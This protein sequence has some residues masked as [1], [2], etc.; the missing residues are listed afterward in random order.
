MTDEELVMFLRDKISAK[1]WIEE[2]RECDHPVTKM[3]RRVYSNDS[4]HYVPQCLRC[5][6]SRPAVKH[7]D[8]RGIITEHDPGLREK[9]Y[10]TVNSWHDRYAERFPF[11]RAHYDQYLLTDVWA[12]VRRRKLDQQDDLCEVCQCAQATQCHHLIYKRLG[13]ERLDDLQAV[14]S[15]CH[16]EIHGHD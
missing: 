16:R 15:D 1:A 7:A 2:H 6:G 8:V 14:C 5:G 10:E 13:D 3:T 11:E 4:V 12:K 9:W